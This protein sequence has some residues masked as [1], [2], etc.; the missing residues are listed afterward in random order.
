MLYCVRVIYQT[1]TYAINA[2]PLRRMLDIDTTKTPEK[3]SSEGSVS[4]ASYH[5]NYSVGKAANNGVNRHL[6]VTSRLCPIY[7]T[8]NPHQQTAGF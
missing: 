5:D 6:P 1:P 3:L 2:V 7:S 4:R 8:S